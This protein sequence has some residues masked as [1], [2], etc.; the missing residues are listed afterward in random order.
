[1]SVFSLFIKEWARIFKNKMTLISIIA[2]FFIP[3]LYSGMFLWSF[4]DPY[5]H[6]ERMPVAVVNN[7]KPATMDNQTLKVGDDLVKKLR[8]NKEFDWKFVDENTAQ[9][10]LKKHHYYMVL[11]IPEDASKN[12]GTLSDPNPQKINFTYAIDESYNF[13]ASMIGRNGAEKIK[14]QVSNS[15][16]E[17]YAEVIF[18]KVAGMPKGLRDAAEGSQKVTDGANQVHN[19]TSQL[20]TGL[21]DK[22]PDIHFLSTGA[23]ELN[24]GMRSFSNGIAQTL[25]GF[26]SLETGAKKVE[27]GLGTLSPG[28]N[29]L[30]SGTTAMKAGIEKATGGSS[31]VTSQ[32]QQYLSKHPELQ[33]DV[34]FQTILV[35][36]KAVTS[37][38]TEINK[39]AGALE[40]GAA[41][42]NQGVEALWTGQKSVTSGISQLKAGQNQLNTSSG[43]LL[44]GTNKLASGTQSLSSAWGGIVTNVS[45]L[46]DGAN[47]LKNGSQELT[48]KLSNAA[49]EANPANTSDKTYSMFA[50]PVKLVNQ[51][52]HKV[53]NYGTGLAPYMIALSLFVGCI[54][55]TIVLDLRDIPEIPKTGF[56]LFI[57]KLATLVIVVTIQGLIVDFLLVKIL[58]LHVKNPDQ[59]ILITV[60]TSITYIALIQMLVKPL[61]DVGRFLAIIILISQITSTGGTFPIETSPGFFRALHPY[62]PMTYSIEGLRAAISSHEPSTFTNSIQHLLMF[63]GAFAIVTW[64]YAFVQ[65][66]VLKHQIER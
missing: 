41:Q 64:I 66:K 4:W 13:V 14:N 16:S 35:T 37:G 28:T 44:A 54:M 12:A 32:L 47:D 29:N 38:L 27:D 3:I 23:S 50:D 7:D 55:L 45:K 25:A 53:A 17:K 48:T 33:T 11:T 31:S 49:E 19:G 26:N 60:L 56:G 20:L 6:L 9:L 10:G 46:N 62:L 63:F 34:E 51:S 30:A 59:F 2:L 22:S 24:N 1:M 57:S 8:E 52:Y 42:V 39:S 5:G 36:S 18:D 21:S 15:I 61:G 43:Q 58:G 65:V 40:V